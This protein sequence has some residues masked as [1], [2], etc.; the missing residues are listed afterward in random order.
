MIQFGFEFLAV[1][2]IEKKKPEKD[3]TLLNIAAGVIVKNICDEE[4]FCDLGI[5]V[6]LVR[7]LRDKLWDVWW[8]NC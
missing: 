8:S 2:R 5:P 7:T 4:D 6:C 1:F 3:M